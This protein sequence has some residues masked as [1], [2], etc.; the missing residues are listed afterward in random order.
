MYAIV[1]TR[2]DISFAVVVVSRYMA[3]PG[4]KHWDAMKHLLRYLKDTLNKCLHF[5]NSE[6]SIVGYKDTDYA[7]CLDRRKSTS[8]Y[9]FLFVGAAVSWRSILQTCTSSSTTESEY[10]AISS[11]SKEAGWHV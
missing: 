1:A 8:G 5:G 3:N 6:A 10:V 4:K 7:G 2:L 11:A 9:V